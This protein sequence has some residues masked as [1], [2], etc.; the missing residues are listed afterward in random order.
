MLRSV[1][2]P[3]GLWKLGKEVARHLL[4]RPVVGIAALPR[5][6]DG[7][8]VLIRR[9]DSGQWALPGGTLEWGET[10]RTAIERELLEEAGTRL[11]ALGEVVG[12]YSRPDRDPRFH[13]VTIV[14]EATVAPPSHAPDNPLEILEVRAFGESELPSELSHGMSEMLK[15]ARAGHKFWE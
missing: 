8:Y 12:V 1:R 11:V 2:I 3:S 6:P 4:R 9:A 13:A 7:R 5:T 10:L 15:N 14:V